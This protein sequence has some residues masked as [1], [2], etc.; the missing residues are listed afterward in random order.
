MKEKIIETLKNSEP[1][2]FD[3][4]NIPYCECCHKAMEE[5]FIDEEEEI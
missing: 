5:E 4:D 1:I 2:F 3:D